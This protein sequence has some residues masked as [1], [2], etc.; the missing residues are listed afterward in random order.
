MAA[1]AE[2]MTSGA[3][4]LTGRDGLDSLK[5]D[6]TAT[7]TEQDLGPED[8]LVDLRAASLNYRDLVVSST[9][10]PMPIIPSL[11]PGSDGA[12]RIIAVGSGVAARRPDLTPG[13]DV[14]TFLAPHVADDELPGFDEITA[15]LGN[16]THGTL[17]R[18]GVFHH[19][20]LVPAPRHLSPAQAATLSCSGVT[21]W[22]ALMGSPGRRP[23]AAGDWVLVQGTGGVSVAAL[24]IAA[25]A[26]ASVVATTSSDA[27][28]ARLRALG[29][30][31]VVNYRAAPDW[32]ARA[33][34][35]HTPGGRGFDHVVD[36]GGPSTL[37]ESLRA[38]RRDGLVTLAGGLGGF[39]S[40]G[41]GGPPSVELMNALWHI[42]SVRGVLLA[43]R[44]MMRDLVAFLEE[45]EVQLAVDDVEFRLE[46]A[47]LAFERLRD[48]KHFSKV[49]IKME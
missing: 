9:P 12:G 2:G 33:R 43:T 46:D 42:C 7:V 24:Q 26:G 45:K 4:T 31:H 17:R 5:Y 18:R 3:W 35:E 11:V 29:A 47:K 37:P 32:G 25:A 28:A 21:A 49:V 10:V 30:A 22:N 13:R 36:V 15:G 48:Q 19:T 44:D 27:K 1:A 23:V 16:Q 14:V 20:A 40:G 41:E 34:R 39:E 8:V 6:P 38:V